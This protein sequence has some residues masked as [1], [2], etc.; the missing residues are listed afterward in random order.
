MHQEQLTWAPSCP[1]PVPVSWSQNPS[2]G[3]GSWEP[4]P[5]ARLGR[6]QRLVEGNCHEQGL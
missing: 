6:K 3:P 1:K 2:S 5:V 4:V